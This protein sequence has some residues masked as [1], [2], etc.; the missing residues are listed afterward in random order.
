METTQIPADVARANPPGMDERLRARRIAVLRSEGRRR[1]RRL[2]IAVGVTVVLLLGWAITRSALLDVDEFVVEGVTITSPVELIAASGISN[3]D[4]LVDVNLAQATKNLSQL[5]WVSE[6][7]IER[8]W[9]GEIKISVIERTPAALVQNNGGE[10]WLVDL[11]GRVLGSFDEYESQSPL[12]ASAENF[13]TISGLETPRPGEKITGVS[14]KLLP[15][16]TSIPSELAELLEAVYVDTEGE[17]WFEL[18]SGS[19][20]VPDGGRIRFGDA[21]SP[22]E[23]LRSAILVVTQVDLENLDVIDVR[24]PSDPVVTRRSGGSQSKSVN[25]IE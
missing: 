11:D 21:R 12:T 15:L 4:A 3:G 22:Y 6:A 13:V 16:V 14:P 10:L 17:I 23:Q 1:L 25:N 9:T 5:P 19:N 8:R 2:L 7:K 20:E 18:A 24:V